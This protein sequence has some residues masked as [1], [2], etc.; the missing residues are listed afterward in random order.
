MSRSFFLKDCYS[1]KKDLA[2]KNQV[3]YSQ[4]KVIIFSQLRLV[5]YCN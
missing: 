1:A 5:L 3:F 2:P 4:E